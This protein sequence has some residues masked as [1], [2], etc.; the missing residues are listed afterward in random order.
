MKTLL[1]HEWIESTG[2]AERVFSE[3]LLMLPEADALCVW[4]DTPEIFGRS[5]AETVLGRYPFRGRKALAMAAM[6][7]VWGCTSLARYDVVVASSHVFAHQ[8]ASRAAR[9]GLSGFAYVHTP[10]RYVWAPE[11]DSRG[12]HLL[13]RLGRRPFQYLDRRRVHSEVHLAANSEFI[14]R[15]IQSAWAMDARVVYPPVD[16][17]RFAAGADLD[18]EAA[19]L[20]LAI[21]TKLP[22]QFILGASRLVPYKR[23][24]LVIELGGEM[25]V[26]VVVA[27]EGP[28]ESRLRRLAGEM[29]HEVHFL[30]RVS[31]RLLHALYQQAMLYCFFAL[32]DFGIMPV[33][34]LASG[35]PV[36]VNSEGGALESV[37]VAGGG[38]SV[39]VSTATRRDLATAARAAIEL[40]PADVACLRRTFS[41]DAFRASAGEWLGSSR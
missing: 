41:V 9:N 14:R 40:A 27:G 12:T 7:A 33:E 8:L 5:I 11:A 4:N 24:D 21:L 13:A 25:G 18:S 17:D 34:A 22:D 32:E 6:P 30:G 2:G 36:L 28:D 1:A 20:D 26:P 35:T 29:A 15:R 19:T 37:L 39:D 31:D 23:L 10:A 3:L 38:L 16:I